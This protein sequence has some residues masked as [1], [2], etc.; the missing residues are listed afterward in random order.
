MEFKRGEVY[1]VKLLA[2]DKDKNAQ[3]GERPIVIVSN[4]KNNMYCNSIDYVPLTGHPKSLH[5]PTHKMLYNKIFKRPSMALC[6]RTKKIDKDFLEN[7]IIRKIGKLTENEM[8]DID[9]G[10]MTHYGIGTQA[11]TFYINHQNRNYS[12]A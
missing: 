11:M 12:F 7:C 8:I 6:E 1:I 5:I 4:D 2:D 3:I 9:M 10:L